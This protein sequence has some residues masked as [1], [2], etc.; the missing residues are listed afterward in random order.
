VCRQPDVWL[1]RFEGAEGSAE[2][3]LDP[4][5][6]RVP[7]DAV[8]GIHAGSVGKDDRV[9]LA[10]LDHFHD[11][12]RR[13]LGVPRRQKG[14]DRD[15]AQFDLVL[16]AKDRVHLGRIECEVL[17]RAVVEVEFAAG[18]EQFYL[19]AHHGDLGACDLLEVSV[20]ADV[21]DVG[22]TGQ[23]QFDVL[24]LEPELGNRFLDHLARTRHPRVQDNV[25]LGALDQVA[26]EALRSDE[27][28]R[29][30]NPRWFRGFVP[31]QELSGRLKEQI[32][33][34]LQ[35]FLLGLRG[36][37]GRDHQQATERTPD[38]EERDLRLHA[39]PP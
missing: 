7:G 9:G 39:E 32:R 30:D 2:V 3:I 14:L 12:G 19:L 37:R 31:L 36:H 27:V 16:V 35:F 23:D 18:L 26:T 22:V 4:L 5:V 21:V 24:R 15:I 8:A 20:T 28:D 38:S 29:P 34:L 17:G 10:V 11:V 33:V 13:A 1:Q 25:A 6:G